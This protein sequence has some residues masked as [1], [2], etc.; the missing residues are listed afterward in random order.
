MA[1]GRVGV[2]T[3]V[4]LPDLKVKQSKSN[5][6]R[7]IITWYRAQAKRDGASTFGLV[8]IL[9]QFLYRGHLTFTLIQL[10]PKAPQAPETKRYTAKRVLIELV[11]V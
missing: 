10:L 7:Q 1:S 11:K 9:V 6:S 3:F 4:F 8:A 2:P 5:P